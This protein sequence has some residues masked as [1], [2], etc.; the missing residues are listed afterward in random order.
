M[1]IG[2][3]WDGQSGHLE[4]VCIIFPG[5]AALLD[6]HRTYRKLNGGLL[7]GDVAV[8]KGRHRSHL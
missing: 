2:I 4:V 3:R 1:P 7:S 6:A 5:L 8:G